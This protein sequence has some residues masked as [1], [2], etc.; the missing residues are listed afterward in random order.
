MRRANGLYLYASLV[1]VMAG[2][3]QR[4]AERKWS[5]FRMSLDTRNGKGEE[6]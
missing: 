2:E 5:V 4:N 1:I 6:K 3:Y